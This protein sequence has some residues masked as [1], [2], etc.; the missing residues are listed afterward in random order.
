MSQ[1]V[2]QKNKAIRAGSVLCE[3]GTTLGS[4]VDVGALRDVSLEGKDESVSITFDNVADITKYKN[5]DQME[6]KANLCEINFTNIALM[7]GGQVNTTSVPGT[8]VTGAVQ[9]ITAGDWA[10]LT[11]FKLSGQNSNGTAPTV[12]SVVGSVDGAVATPADYELVKVGNEW[13]IIL[14]SGG[15]ITTLA[16]DIVVTS[17]Y[18][19]AASKRTT[20]NAT[21]IKSGVYMR[22]KNT[23]EDGNTLTYTFK[24][25][26][27]TSPLTF[28]FAG[29]TEDNVAEM[30]ITLK[31]T[32]IDIVDE[33]QTT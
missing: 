5:G 20:L 10:Y 8:P 1:T 19:P 3:L 27:N 33:Q 31:G 16:Q 15:D 24:D 28:N 25:V 17:D 13:A 26:V 29:D 30:P 18:T 9:T 14:K 23:D 7:S 12:T 4:M 21:G 11:P 22:L 32:V 6:F 2:I